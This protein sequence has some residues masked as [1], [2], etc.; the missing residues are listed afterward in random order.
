MLKIEEVPMFRIHAPIIIVPTAEVREALG[1]RLEAA[2]LPPTA[3]SP[4]P[5]RD[6]R[7]RIFSSSLVA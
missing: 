7:S 1:P 2:G 6:L 3:R 5:R 4:W